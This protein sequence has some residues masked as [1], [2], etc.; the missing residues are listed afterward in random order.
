MVLPDLEAMIYSGSG[1]GNKPETPFF[2]LGLNDGDYFIPNVGLSLTGKVTENDRNKRLLY[3]TTAMT[4]EGTYKKYYFMIHHAKLKMDSDDTELRNNNKKLKKAQAKK[5][6][7]KGKK[8]KSAEATEVEG[9]ST[10]ETPTSTDT[11][12]NGQEETPVP[13]QPVLPE[14]TIETPAP[15]T[16]QL[17]LPPLEKTD[18]VDS[19]KT[20]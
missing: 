11:P 8:G 14:T 10:E 17:Q 5:A 1:K 4:D 6:S 9:T 20:E 16:L 13:D 3:V 12:T 2:A 19:T 15:D 7:K 18:R